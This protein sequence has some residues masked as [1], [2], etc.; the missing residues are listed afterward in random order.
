M[1]NSPLQQRLSGEVC[2]SDP[3]SLRAGTY[4]GTGSQSR[5]ILNRAGSAAFCSR[6]R[7]CRMMRVGRTGGRAGTCAHN[8]HPPSLGG[9]FERRHKRELEQK[10]LRLTTK[11]IRT[12]IRGNRRL[13]SAH[14]ANPFLPQCSSHSRTNQKPVPGQARGG[15]GWGKFV[16]A[17]LRFMP[18][19]DR[20]RNWQH[21]GVGEGANAERF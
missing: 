10:C 15:A 20:R 12:S 7:R 11:R 6:L 4:G 21:S 8:L 17:T 1:S 9:N 5:R 14:R 18:R 16:R 3:D 13:L 19:A 2:G